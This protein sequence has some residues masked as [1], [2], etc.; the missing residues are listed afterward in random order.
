MSTTLKA[1]FFWSAG[2]GLRLQGE[3]AAVLACAKIIDGIYHTST[4]E[5]L[6]NQIKKL[7]L[8]VTCP[9]L[10]AG[11]VDSVVE[12]LLTYDAVATDE[13]EKLKNEII[14]Q[15]EAHQVIDTVH[16]DFP[17]M[18][19]RSNP[20]VL[21]KMLE[22]IN[23]IRQY[24]LGAKL[25][26]DMANSQKT[27]LIVHDKSSIS[28]GGY[29][30]AIRTTSDVFRPGVGADARIRFR[31]DMP[32]HGTHLVSA[33]NNQM[34]PFTALDI[35]FHEMVHT[36]HIMSGT[37]ARGNSERQAIEEENEFRKER[38]ET[39]DWP[40]RDWRAYEHDQQIWFGFD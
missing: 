27:L 12:L 32:D 9:E 10:S 1:S 17:F 14:D 33:Y 2:V 21:D 39:K 37:F 5:I 28:V 23:L 25:F 7:E 15:Y 20:E 40:E 18:T 16:P 35:L 4:G 6:I 29:A 3:K 38:E 31:F 11:T 26:E 36:K 24:P 13:K 19:L 34:I 22:R 30:S 8:I